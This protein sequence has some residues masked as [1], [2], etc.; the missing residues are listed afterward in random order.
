MSQKAIA[1]GIQI[2]VVPTPELARTWLE[3][4]Q[5][6]LLPNVVLL[7]L[8]LAESGASL[9]DLEERLSLIAEFNLLVSSIPVMIIADRDRFGDRL[10]VARHG[11]AFYLKQPLLPSQAVCFCQQLLERSSWG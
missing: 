5:D 7:R 9:I 1:E 2:V 4:L 11:G 3:G 10:L 6:R 8:S